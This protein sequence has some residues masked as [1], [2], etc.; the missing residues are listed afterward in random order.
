MHL[1]AERFVCGGE[2]RGFLKEGVKIHPMASMSPQ[3]SPIVFCLHI[4]SLRM[5][6]RILRL[7]R[8]F[9]EFIRFFFPQK[10]A[11]WNKNIKKKGEERR[12]GRDLFK[13]AAAAAAR[14]PHLIWSSRTSARSLVT[15]H[16]RETLK[17]PAGDSEIKMTKMDNISGDRYVSDPASGQHDLTVASGSPFNSDSPTL[18]ILPF[19]LFYR[20]LTGESS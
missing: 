11:W 3:N 5:N 1:L 4:C 13:G 18:H 14:A 8:T 19:F 12:K 10:F 20:S 15:S 2:E 6:L 17:S 9:F 7:R 16:R